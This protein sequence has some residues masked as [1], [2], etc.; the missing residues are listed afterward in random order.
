MAKVHADEKEFEH[1]SY[2]MA[3]FSRLHGS[4]GR[5]FGSAIANHQTHVRLRVCRAR[6]KHHLGQDWFHADLESIIEVD[7]SPAQFAE[8]LV[9][10]NIGSGVP[11]TLRRLDGTRIEDPPDEKLEVEQ[12]HSDFAEKTGIVASRLDRLRVSVETILAKKTLINDDRKELRAQIDKIIQEVRSNLPFWL[13]QLHESA[14]K[15]VVAARAEIDA[16]MTSAVQAAGL[17]ALRGPEAPPIPRL[18]GK[19]DTDVDNVR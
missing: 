3:S 12:I 15:V 18:N 11:C 17:K 4:S 9:T 2:V 14:E 7:L 8:L 13:E 5:L 1:P 19:E 10:M 16:F 6:R